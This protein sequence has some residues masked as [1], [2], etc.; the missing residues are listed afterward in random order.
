MT[1][2]WIAH[3]RLLVLTVTFL[4]ITA[5]G[6]GGGSSPA[7][8][9]DTTA[10]VITLNGAN[11][12]T[13][14]QGATYVEAGATATDD[15]DGTVA[16]VITGTVD[17][18]TLGSYT[19]TYTARDA[20]NNSAVVTR[21]VN[22]VPDTIEPVIT[23]L[24]TNPVDVIVNTSY[25][26]AGAT[27]FDNIDGDITANISTTS[28]VDSST[29]G[30]YSVTYN[31]S[32]AAG[33]SATPVVRTVN[34]T[35]SV[36]DNA[37]NIGAGMNN[38]VT[39]IAPAIDG[40]YDVYVGGFFETVNGFLSSRLVRMNSDGTVDTDFNVG[41]GLNAAPNSIAPA[42]DGSGDVYV[43]GGFIT[44][45]S[46]AYNRLI[47]LNSDGSVDSGFDIGNGITGLT[48]YVISI[49]PAIDGS[50]DIYVG[51]V[52]TNY[53]GSTHNYLVRLNSNGT[54]DSG[55][56]IGTGMNYIVRCVAPATDGSGDVYVGGSF[57]SV[58]GAT[59]NYLVRLNS[60]G[61][62]DSGFNLGTGMDN[63]VRSIAPATDGSGDIYVGGVFTTV[64]GATHNRLVRLNSD[65][66][67]DTAFNI[68]TGMDNNV[69]TI[70]PTVDGTGDVYVGGHY[71]NING[72][73]HLRLVRFNSTGTVDNGF[74]IGSGMNS[75]VLTAAIAID[76]SD[77]LYVGGEFTSVNTISSN[78]LV[79]LNPDGTVE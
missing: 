53:N 37:F 6:G 45:D 49:A 10:P 3:V 39:S 2:Q 46:I 78:F 35:T 40:S 47:R 25:L 68:G 67:V 72:T 18:N 17:T 56:N 55:F 61:T 65:G 42:I 9:A 28:T 23:L 31:V 13:V 50:G 38:L 69:D 79:G 76:G 59:H 4:L 30:T 14:I 54:V 21:T 52:F 32:D 74:N 66:T 51:G 26:D 1:F 11:P 63:S 41:T 48:N 24:G 34:V 12:A 64:N 71:V 57:T 5:C 44:Y 36:S 70:V 7:P 27:A 77:D 60:N 16:V 73:A 20:A 43:G 8:T 62:V 15:T 58:N 19:V 33:N 29:V 22:V 75:H